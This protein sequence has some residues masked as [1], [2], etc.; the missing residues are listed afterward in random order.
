MALF[1]PTRP[2]LAIVRPTRAKDIHVRLRSTQASYALTDYS[3]NDLYNSRIKLPV[4][5]T[6]IAI[7]V[8]RDSFC[9]FAQPMLPLCAT[10]VATSS[11]S[12]CEFARTICDF[13]RPKLRFCVTQAF[14]SYLATLRDPRCDF[15]RLKPC[16]SVEFWS[17]EVHFSDP[18]LSQHESR[19]SARVSVY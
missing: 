14:F 15:V 7:K 5:T 6:H 13:A 2:K 17:Q 11:D 1:R 10:H 9:D 8:S 3:D 18:L 16:G 19:T 4:C 12:C